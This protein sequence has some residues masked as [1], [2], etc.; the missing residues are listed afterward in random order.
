MNRWDLS[1]REYPSIV[2]KALLGVLV[3]LL[4][5][6]ALAAPGRAVSF[7]ISYSV[8]DDGDPSPFAF[9]FSQSLP[10]LSSVTG[11]FSL[12]GTMTD[13]GDGAVSVS[14]DQNA[15]FTIFES[16]G[17][18]QSR[19]VVPGGSSYSVSGTPPLPPSPFLQ[20]SFPYQFPFSQSLCFVFGTP[21]P[22]FFDG[23]EFSFAFTG[24][25]GG[26][27]YDLSG[28]ITVDELTVSRVPEPTT[29]LLV[30]SGLLGMVALR[31]KLQ[32]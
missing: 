27:R 21:S 23:I 22:C 29:F 20:A 8:T 18:Y 32:A 28:S 13:A 17:G 14:V 31:R 25:G 3:N 7:D 15:L 11:T 9:S 16:S 12:T 6:L 19:V 1:E 26:D 4:L 24:S 10:N 30:G 2:G 5:I